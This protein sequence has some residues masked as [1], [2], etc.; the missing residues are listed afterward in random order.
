MTA[1][2]LVRV[3]QQARNEAKE[4]LTGLERIGHPE[5]SRSNSLYLSLVM[6]QKR[7]VAKGAGASLAEFV[8][9]LD[10]F[11]GLCDGKL[12]PLKA[13]LA[14]AARIARGGRVAP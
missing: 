2:A 10:Q 3:I 5:T 6:L 8:T 14:E 4:I 11:A 13:R 7:V 1:E 12:A 9:E